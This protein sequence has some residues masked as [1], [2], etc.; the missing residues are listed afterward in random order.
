MF[1]YVKVNSA[2][3]KV[4]E[5]E[6]YR[7]TYCGLCRSM[8]KCTGQCSRMTLSYDFVFLALV[9]LAVSSTKTEFEQKRCLAH[10]LKKRNSMIRNEVLD[11]CS[12]AAAILNYQ[13]VADD[14]KD[15][16]G[17]KLFRARMVLPF[18]S[19]ARK[20]AIK[21]DPTLKELDAAV[22]RELETLASIENDASSGV[23]APADSFGRLLGEIM[24]FGLDGS[25]K[26]ITYEIGKGVGGW[27]Y[28][29]DAIDDVKDDSKK[30]RYNPLLKLYGGRVPDEREL[31]MISVAIKN[32][33]FGAEGA[34]DLLPTERETVNNILANVLFLGIPDTTDK[35]IRSH[36][37]KNDKEDKGKEHSHD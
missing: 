20:K 4:R 7:G 12:K 1:G 3:L 15:E 13:K 33:L 16:K 9:R 36:S 25:A 28:I 34:F 11:Y 26:R 14:L 6:F 29:A 37:D 10:P 27:I 2:E 32:R 24:S 17:F 22:A 18:V 35:I 23:D 8:G 5:Y 30:G 19:H 21:K 31:E